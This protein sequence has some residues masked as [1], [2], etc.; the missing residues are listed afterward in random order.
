MLCPTMG[1]KRIAQT[2]ARAGLHLGVTTVGRILKEREDKQPE[3]A[4]TGVDEESMGE[5]VERSPVRAKKPNDVCH[6][7]YR[8]CLGFKA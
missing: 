6:V 8:L 7:C 3:P 5:L 4:E 2:L 1:K